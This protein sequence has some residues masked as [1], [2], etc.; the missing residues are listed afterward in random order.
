MA[1]ATASQVSH[2]STFLR[3]YNFLLNFSFHRIF[4]LADTALCAGAE[5]RDACDGDGGG[6]LV[7]EQDGQWYQVC[8]SVHPSISFW[9]FIDLNLPHFRLVL[10]ALASGVGGLECRACTPGYRASTP[11]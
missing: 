7:C 5:G 3:I 4:F 8:T 1:P 9:D 2:F 11:G 6:P 10:S